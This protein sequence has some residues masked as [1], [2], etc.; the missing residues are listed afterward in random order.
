MSSGLIRTSLDA[1]DIAVAPT[2]YGNTSL[3]YGVFWET[4]K[5]Q[6]TV[7]Q[8]LGYLP[9][10]CVFTYL[11]G[12]DGVKT[13]DAS[14]K[15]LTIGC[16]VLVTR[17]VNMPLM[18]STGDCLISVIYDPVG[19]IMAMVHTGFMGMEMNLPEKVVQYLKNM[20]SNPRDLQVWIG[21]GIRKDSYIMPTEKVLQKNGEK[22]K[23]YLTQV[24]QDTI[25]ID[26]VGM[27]KDSLVQSGVMNEHIVDSGLDMAAA[28]NLYSHYRAS[29]TGEKEGRNAV[30]AIMK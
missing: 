24:D 21:P 22:W 19:K 16:D 11:I 14:H 25:Q 2:S 3:R 7:L 10:D 1:V 26:L 17:E 9:K 12:A 6:E 28:T 8:E 30:V 23:N 15:A 29:R 27:L 13:V 4:I 5:N 20:K 18:M